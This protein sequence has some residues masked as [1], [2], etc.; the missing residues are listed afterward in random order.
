LVSSTGRK[1]NEVISIASDTASGA[2]K[3]PPRRL[4]AR[5]HLTQHGS[6]S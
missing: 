2:K 5:H 4:S 3:A 6:A 1:Q